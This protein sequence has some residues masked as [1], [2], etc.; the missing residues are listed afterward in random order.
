MKKD[1][2]EEKVIKLE[3][4]VR[5]N[6]EQI[7]Q[8][9]RIESKQNGEYIKMQEEWQS[10]KL[11]IDPLKGHLTEARIVYNT[12]LTMGKDI[13]YMKSEISEVKQLVT[14][15]Y[16]QKSDYEPV[17]RIVYGLVSIILTAVVV[18]IVALVLQK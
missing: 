10:I 3:E 9:Y 4:L 15:Q 8:L 14:T 7:A 5:Q 11:Q 2:I 16:V 17:K 12:V 1:S 6:N 13:E 18:A